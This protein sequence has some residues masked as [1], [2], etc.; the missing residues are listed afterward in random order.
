MQTETWGTGTRVVLVHGAITNGPSAWSKQRPLS[1]EWQLVVVNRPGFVPNPP[2][3]H[4]DFEADA[5]GLL[6][7]LE[8]PA[9]VVGHSYGGL[10]ALLAASYRPQ[11]VLSLVVI[12]PPAMSLL[13]GDPEV[14]ASIDRHINLVESHRSSPRAFLTAFT[15]SLGGDPAGVPDPLPDA[16]CQHVELLINE[17][18][19]WEADIPS[20]ALSSAT[21]PKLVIS[22]GH[23]TMQEHMCD[24][25][26][27]AISAERE[28]VP[29]AGHNVQRAEGC[30]S[31]LD[32]FWREPP[33]RRPI[34]N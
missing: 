21:F 15:A 24:V 16:L 27:T 2:A 7:L 31:R 18:F 32:R 20:S 25:L 9:H 6:E 4:C 10:I 11:D 5:Q 3:E 1:E 17:R 12:E 8:A 23:S 33:A 26:A 22:G 30:N 19:P 29:G 14:E 28:T 13:R 34:S